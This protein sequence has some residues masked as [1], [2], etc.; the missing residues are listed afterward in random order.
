MSPVGVSMRPFW[1]SLQVGPIDVESN[2]PGIEQSREF[3]FTE[4][5]THDIGLSLDEATM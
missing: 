4:I 1:L 5:D 3:A 2:Q